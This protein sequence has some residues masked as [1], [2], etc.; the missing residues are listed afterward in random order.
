MSALLKI[1]GGIACFMDAFDDAKIPRFESASNDDDT[2]N[3]TSTHSEGTYFY[4]C[5]DSGDYCP[6]PQSREW[7]SDDDSDSDADD[8]ASDSIAETAETCARIGRV[9]RIV[10]QASHIAARRR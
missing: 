6:R 7:H 9:L 1:I 3:E 5:C 2:E 4:R 10:N 8:S